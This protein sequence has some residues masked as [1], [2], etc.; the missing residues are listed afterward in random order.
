MK[1]LQE[2]LGIARRPIAIGLFDEA[3]AGVARWDGG[4]VPA[5]CAFWR[6][7]AEGRTFYTTPADHYNCAVGAYVHNIALPADR[8]AVLKETVSF[9]VL[10]GYLQSEEVPLIPALT[11]PPRFVAYGPADTVPFRKDVVVIA[12]RPAE[13]MLIYEAAIRCGAAN[14]AM[15][16]LGR[17]GCA[18]L[19]LALS[20]AS[21]AL[22]FGCK[23]N[24]T[25]TGLP[26]EEM[27]FSI[28]G[29]R[30]DSLLDTLRTIR[31]ANKAME[32]HYHRHEAAVR[33]D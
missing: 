14:M 28:P 19:P 15:P 3:P 4:P 22:S 31:Q 1:T 25:F 32:A 18:V 29:T 20:S 30:W 10:N 11:K 7:A 2:T 5:G 33:G 12:A 8:G 27:Y 26:D 17:P 13:A 6:T 16:A 23:G 9:M 24:R 21:S